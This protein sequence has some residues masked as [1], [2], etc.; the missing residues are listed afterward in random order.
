MVAILRGK[1]EDRECISCRFRFGPL[2]DN[3]GPKI[4]TAVAQKKFSAFYPEHNGWM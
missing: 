1:A 3:W 4:K 2:H